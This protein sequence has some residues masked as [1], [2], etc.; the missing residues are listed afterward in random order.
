MSSPRFVSPLDPHSLLRSNLSC[1]SGDIRLHQDRFSDENLP[2]NLKLFED[3]EKAAKQ[4]GITPAQLSLAWLIA[5]SPTGGIVPIPGTTNVGRIKENAEA[6]NVRLTEEEMRAF[7]A[8]ID[9]T[10]V[11]GERY[12]EQARRV[13]P[14]WG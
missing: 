14:L 1:S 5:Q 2:K 10:Q 8:L 3:Y 12:S 11:A 13:Q 9:S 4:N 6:A 7:R